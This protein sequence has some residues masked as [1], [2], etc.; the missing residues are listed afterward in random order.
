MKQPRKLLA[1][2]VTFVLLLSILNCASFSAVFLHDGDHTFNA[3]ADIPSV[4]PTCTE[5]GHGKGWIC[6]KEGCDYVAWEAGKQT[7]PALGHID[8]DHDTHCDRCGTY[9]AVSQSC[10]HNFIDHY[11]KPDYLKSTATCTSKAVYYC[12]CQKCGMP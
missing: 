4:A 10:E 3:E 2:L 12:L 8:R 6:N 7:I 5:P 11:A 9:V 1:L